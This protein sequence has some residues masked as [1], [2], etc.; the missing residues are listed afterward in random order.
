MFPTTGLVL[1]ESPL[2]Y[3]R[4]VY[5]LNYRLT[6]IK[7]STMKHLLDSTKELLQI[8]LGRNLR[9]K[10]KN[11][12]TIQRRSMNWS[13][14]R[15]QIKTPTSANTV[16]SHQTR[17]ISRANSENCHCSMFQGKLKAK[18]LAGLVSTLGDS[19]LG[20]YGGG[21]YTTDDGQSV[22]LNQVSVV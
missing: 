7:N 17:A 13:R 16:G 4:S 8:R 1:L 10:K 12:A 18:R 21:S 22:K 3:K 9:K 19:A 2:S 6:N 11:C 5:I 14:Q 20:P 15:Y